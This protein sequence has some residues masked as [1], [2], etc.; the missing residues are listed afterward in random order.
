MK[1]AF[2]CVLLAALVASFAMLTGCWNYQELENRYVVSGIAVDRG[3]QGHRYLLT[4]EV[5]DLSGAGNG[6]AG[7]GAGGQMKGKLI[8]SE[9]DTIADA[10]DEASKISDKAL[11]YSDCKIVVFSKEIA[12][13]GLTPVLDWLNRDPKPRF[14]VQAFVSQEETAGELFETG[15]Q[16]DGVISTEIANSM[17][18]ASTGGKSLQVHLYDIDNILLGEGRDL[19]LP[20][21]RESGQQNPTV[22]VNGTAVFRG[23][24]Y[25]GFLD[26]DQTENYLLLLN[27]MQNSV[28]LVGEKPEEKNLAL[29]VRQSSVAISPETDGGKISMKIKIKMECSFDEEKQRQKLFFRPGSEAD[30]ELC[31][32][33]AA[34]A[35]SAGR[36]AGADGIRLRHFRIRPEN[37][38]GKAER[39]AEAEAVLAGKIPHGFGGGGGGC[40][41]RRHGIHAAERKYLT[42]STSSFPFCSSLF[43]CVP[44]FCRI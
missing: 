18:A 21:L 12:A 19:A 43:S 34:R 3:K 8:R 38:S 44:T 31:E 28:L 2:Q 22:E 39:M 25:A 1:R 9:G 32:Q 30:R 24:K 11:Y 15:G 5:L 40:I 6:G 10:V 27:G 33:H 23:D 41:N 7:G 35:R 29:L 37:L 36:A 16:S 26:D 17:E 42:W 14:T 13:E 4:F 20:C